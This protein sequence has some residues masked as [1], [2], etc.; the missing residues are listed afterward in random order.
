MLYFYRMGSSWRC[1]CGL[2]I[3][4]D[5]S[6]DTSTFGW[7]PR[8]DLKGVVDCGSAVNEGFTLID[9]TA[10]FRYRSDMCSIDALDFACVTMDILDGHCVVN[11]DGC[12]RGSCKEPWLR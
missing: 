9:V 10:M 5:Y 8:W 2:E 12:S 7:V 6:R 1:L 4:C 3:I 11:I